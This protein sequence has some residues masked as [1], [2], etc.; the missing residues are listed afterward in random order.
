MKF[1]FSRKSPL[2][3]LPQN[4]SQDKHTVC[5]R[6]IE[7]PILRHRPR[8]GQPLEK[9]GRRHSIDNI[10]LYVWCDEEILLLAALVAEPS[11]VV[12]RNK[13]KKIFSEPQTHSTVPDGDKII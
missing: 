6:V 3:I 11:F 13:L 4:Q 8:A 9:K 5:L 2:K 12:V 7:A 1:M 10:E